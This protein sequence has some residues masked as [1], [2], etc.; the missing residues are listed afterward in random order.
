[1]NYRRPFSPLFFLEQRIVIE[2]IENI[3]TYGLYIFVQ[4]GGREIVDGTKIETNAEASI[5]GPAL[6][7]LLLDCVY[8]GFG[9]VSSL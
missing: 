7:C 8:I 4:G 5:F 6:S 2:F 3:F 1:M 9:N